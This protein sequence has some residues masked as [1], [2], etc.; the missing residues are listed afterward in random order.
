[1]DGTGIIAVPYDITKE[2]IITY[3][4]AIPAQD[5]L[6]LRQV[7][8][9]MF[10]NGKY[11]YL[12]GH[13]RKTTMGGNVDKSCHPFQ[14]GDITMV[15]NGSIRNKHELGP[16]SLDVDSEAICH[17][18]NERGADETIK[19]IN[20]AFALI[21]HDKRD[22][23]L[24][25][26]RNKERPLHFAFV[27]G[28]DTVLLS[29]EYGMLEW[30]SNRNNIKIEKG[31]TLG[32]EYIISFGKD[33]YRKYE[34]RKVEYAKEHDYSKGY[35]TNGRWVDYNYGNDTYNRQYKNPTTGNG[36]KVVSLP[37]QPKNQGFVEAALK[38]LD[39]KLNEF[40]EFELIEY[41]KYTTSKQGL[42]KVEGLPVGDSTF[43]IEAHGVSEEKVLDNT[44]Y[45]GKVVG[46]RKDGTPT[47]PYY[48]VILADIE[49][50]EYFD[51]EEKEDN[52]S[53]A[54]LFVDKDG[55]SLVQGPGKVFIPKKEFDT[56]TRHGCSRCSG[57][58]FYS[59]APS[60]LWIN[61]ETPICPKCVEED[62]NQRERTNPALH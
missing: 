55:E 47:A 25:I 36:K 58:I 2:D 43:I 20:G 3:K 23:T 24:N 18:I 40:I 41:T 28:E 46:I 44:T 15:H 35:W 5:F 17:S 50:V 56:L 14:Y 57:N 37:N 4:R 10:D 42:G 6:Q 60:M 51:Y 27:E 29:S 62:A 26:V 12:I 38:T 45:S 16:Y 9:I 33:T 21:W 13:T 39:L 54:N 34:T 8:R 19:K 1:M 22:H 48:A 49:P 32:L 61:S 11:K 7:E 52:V 59:D 31:F 30:I 53:T